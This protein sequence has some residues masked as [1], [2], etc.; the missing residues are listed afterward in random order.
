MT[1][2]TKI[3]TLTLIGAAAFLV[4]VSVL[5]VLLF[6]AE[7]IRALVETEAAKAV[8]MPVKIG[9]LGLRALPLPAVK[10]SGIVIGPARTG[11]PPLLTVKSA[12]VRVALLPLLGKRIEIVSFRM[13]SPSVTIITRKDRTSNLPASPDTTKQVKQPQMMPPIPITLKSFTMKNGAVRILDEAKGTEL[14]LGGI[15]QDLSLRIGG[16]LTTL[17]SSGK[18]EIGSVMSRSGGKALPLAG[19]RIGFA[20]TLT[21]NPAAGT[22]TLSKG[23]LTLNGL[24]VKITGALANGKNCSFKVDTGT[25]D[26][27]RLI[28]ALPDSVLPKRRDL[29]VSG[30]FSLALGGTVDLSKPKP[31]AVYSGELAIR[32]MSLAV[33]GLPKRIDSL[34]AMVAITDR[35]LTFR[36]TEIRIGG[37][38]A[39]LTGTVGNYLAAPSLALRAEGSISLE[40]AVSAIPA[41]ASSGL[42]G[43]LTFDLKADGP[44]AHPDSLR[45]NGRADLRGLKVKVPKVLRNPAEM[46]G[47]ILITPASVELTGLAVKSGKSDLTLSGRLT[48]YVNLL[49]AGKG[50]PV[51][52]TGT[53]GSKLFDI[54]DMF[55]I[56][57]NAP[58]IKPWDLEKPLKN[59]PIPPTLD[60]VLTIAMGKVVFGKLAADT[61]AG[62]LTLGKGQFQLSGL[63]VKAYSG[64]LTGKTLMNF[65]N[66]DRITY[67]GGFDLSK[68]DARTFLS[69]FFGAGDNFRGA[70]SSSLTFN[71]AGLDSVSFFKNLKGGGSALLEK[72]Q[73][74]NWDFTKGLGSALKFL[75]FDTLD[76]DVLQTAFSIE[77]GRV[78]TPAAMM[79]TGYGDFTF[80]GSTGFDTSVAYDIMIKLNSR[81]MSIAGKNGLGDLASIIGAS[82]TPELYL[83]A[84]GTLKKPAF[85]IDRTRSAAAVKEKIKGEAEKFLQNQNGDVLK[86]GKKLLDKLFK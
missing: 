18:I 45:I 3:L 67:S 69:S 39:S 24:T 46:N 53:L 25:L 54:G 60:A 20:H 11:E 42:A 48:D 71:G 6:P 65:A 77:N 10:V 23:E 76:F 63:T 40:E 84:K 50:K 51:R 34:Q 8:G 56:D 59:M 44:S 81:A 5:A 49:P 79:K 70:F 30:T 74:V 58:L 37:S 47:A 27:S 61:V 41:L 32:N 75:N 17:E 15:D 38:R 29:T 31:A 21:G 1:R 43:G 16:S 72:G 22:Y 55:I 86:Q 19:L 66:P 85:S 82:S 80:S 78:I 64:S 33:K 12:R 13:D 4:V 35:A 14:A 68:L 9:S 57:K 73:F 62:T 7:R 2:R 26:A 28:A 83:T 36:D 52:L